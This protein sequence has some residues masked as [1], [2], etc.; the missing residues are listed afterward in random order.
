[1]ATDQELNQKR[2]EAAELRRKLLAREQSLFETGEQA[3]PKSIGIPRAALQGLTFGFADEIGAGAAAAA[4]SIL[5]SGSDD[6]RDVFDDILFNLELDRRRFSKR[7]P[8]LSI[9][10]EIA[11]GV[12]QGGAVLRGAERLA[13][14]IPTMFRLG[15]VGALEGSAFGAGTAQ[16]GERLQGAGGG[17]LIGAAGGPI[18]GGIFSLAGSALRPVVRNLAQSLFDTPKSKASRIIFQ[19]LDADDITLDEAEFLLRQLGPQGTLADIGENLTRTARVATAQTGP[20]AAKARRFL[21]ARQTGQQRRLL[22][23]ARRATG[24]D[25]FDSGIIEILNNAE[26]KAAGLYDQAFSQVVD[27]TQPLQSILARPA[28]KTATKKAATLLRNEGFATEIVGDVTDVRYLDAIKRSLDDQIGVSVRK[29]QR[30]NVRVLTEL[31]NDF[32]SQID[33]QVPVYREA[34]NIFAGEAAIRDAAD[35]GR[36]LLRKTDVADAAEVVRRMNDSELQAFRI[37]VL[38]NLADSLSGT[39]ETRNAAKRLVETPRFRNL[40]R[41]A[42]PDEDTFEQ[43]LNTARAESTFSQTRGTVLGGSPTARIQADQRQVGGGLLTRLIDSALSPASSIANALRSVTSGNKLTPEV[44][45]EMAKI[46]FDPNVIPKKIRP[47]AVTS[48][49]DI[50]PTNPSVFSGRVGGAVGSQQEG[51]LGVLEDFGLVGN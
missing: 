49:F 42:F 5:S 21:D 7:H 15:G 12:A 36:N 46:L 45:D 22:Q 17:A 31:K 39:A 41:T 29:G 51:L 6:F 40:I 32:L 19:A 18:A 27:V 11:G 16:P 34:R 43:F 28:M 10:T 30:N 26:S 2:L 9:G 33:N 25:D 1:M 23:A 8:A 47:S 14:N 20:A 4:H 48:I 38:R 13:R 35:F 44:L 37:G 3:P 24:S 50:P